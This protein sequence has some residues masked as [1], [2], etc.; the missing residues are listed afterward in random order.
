MKIHREP[1]TK[2]SLFGI[3]ERARGS[4]V[5]FKLLA[6]F[7]ERYSLVLLRETKNSDLVSPPNCSEDYAAYD[8]LRNLQRR[9]DESF[10]DSDEY[11]A[12]L[13]EDRIAGREG[14]DKWE[15]EEE[16]LEDRDHER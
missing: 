3:L 2:L 5:D 4:R 14:G 11:Q 7:R 8:A 9:Y 1:W 16:M 6:S 13:K 12:Q 10:I 15:I